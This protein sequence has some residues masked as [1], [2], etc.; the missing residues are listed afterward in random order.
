[1]RRLNLTLLDARLTNIAGDVTIEEKG[2]RITYG[3][4]FCP[5]ISDLFFGVGYLNRVMESLK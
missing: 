5:F 3:G 2:L 1:M 4:R